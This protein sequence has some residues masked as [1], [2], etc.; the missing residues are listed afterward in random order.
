MNLL[1]KGIEISISDSQVSEIVR[2]HFLNGEAPSLQR[3]VPQL[4]EYWAEQG[5]IYVG[6]VYGDDGRSH[7]HLIVGPEMDG[8]ATWDKSMEWAKALNVDGKND[9]TLPNR[10]ELRFLYCQAKHLHKEACYWSGEQHA[11]YS[12]T[13]WN[14][15]FEGGDQFNWLKDLNGRARAVRRLAI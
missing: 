6:T 10:R 15:A 14:Q 11:S 5:G 1:V 7:Y 8:E 9:F 12:L 3:S 4:G 13:A 2:R